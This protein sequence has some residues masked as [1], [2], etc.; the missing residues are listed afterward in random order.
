MN[1]LIKI[2]KDFWITPQKELL[3]DP[4]RSTKR[5]GQLQHEQFAYIA[6]LKWKA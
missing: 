5:E 6:K 4:H 3:P 1:H 2:L